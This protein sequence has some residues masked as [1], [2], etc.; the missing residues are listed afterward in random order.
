MR[1]RYSAH[2]LGEVDYLV[3]TTHP[4]RRTPDLAGQ[5]AAWLTQA[6]FSSLKVLRCQQGGAADKVGKVEFIA[7]Y[8]QAGEE[9]RLHEISRFR[10]FQSRW[11]YV[12][13][14]FAEEA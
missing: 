12:D 11:M 9:R 5:I 1:S 14:R 2:A 6:D 10:R 7:C 4:E 13:G 8:R 3:A